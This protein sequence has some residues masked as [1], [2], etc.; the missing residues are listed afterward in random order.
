VRKCDRAL[1]WVPMRS[2]P[3]KVTG[4]V[5]SAHPK[6]PL[7]PLRS[8]RAFLPAALPAAPPA[9]P[10]LQHSL[11]YFVRL[12]RLMRPYWGEMGASLALGLVVGLLG[13]IGPYFTKSYFDRVYPARDFTLLHALVLGA[14]TL[15]LTTSVVGSLR[16][17]HADAIASKVSAAVGLMYFNHL[18]HLPV[19]FYE[20]RHV[21]E[22]VSRLSDVNAS[23]ATIARTLQTVLMSG[24]YFLIVPPFLISLSWKLSLVA[25][26]TTP[27]TIAVATFTGRTSRRL[28]QRSA[29]ASA[30]LVAAQVE[31]LSHIRLCKS[32]AA[33]H[34][35]YSDVRAHAHGVLTTHLRASG[36]SMVIA[37][38]NS[39]VAALGA[40]VFAWYAWTLV[41]RGEM[42]IGGYLAFA[43]YLGLLTGPA[44]QIASLVA[45]F[46]QSAVSL[47]RTF[48][49]LDH[50]PEQA[51]E[52][53]YERPAAIARPIR[54]ELTLAHV[55]FGYTDNS[56]I[57]R[58]VSLCFRPGT[59][60]ALVGGSGA[61]KSSLIKLLSRSVAA[62]RGALHVD[63]RPFSE[64]PLSEFRRQVSVVW[65]D[66]ALF[67]GTVLDNLVTRGEEIAASCLED[68]VRACRLDDYIA[69]LR[70]GYATPV[71]EWGANMSGGQRQR[72]AL[73]RA[74][75][76]KTPILLLDEATSQLDMETEDLVLR[77]IIARAREQTLVFATHRVATASLAHQ[78][79][80]LEEGRVVEFGTHE[81]LSRSNGI[82][83]RMLRVAPTGDAR[84]VQARGNA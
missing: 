2:A 69:C 81:H 55:S 3:L 62:N 72:F 21:G 64:V 75:L 26:M 37:L 4:P 42:T 10:S 1:Y 73:A 50:E 74:L 34:A 28:Y 31:I 12:L 82:Y 8:M 47:G 70:D 60:T 9:A 43:A 11:G 17:Y 29:E 38:I 45:D 14:L 78:V 40:A 54:G 7:S 52:S 6:L 68:A 44:G 36:G 46:Q 51:A 33:E 13:L 77:A 84:S 27:L 48:E 53:A 63:G 32:L 80:V 22:V 24:L 57:L 41:L 58:D 30:A 5:Q 71:A 59:V 61:G 23:L 16:G 66:Q 76:R 19:S 49:Y 18:Q 83:E 67:R 79:C 39:C 15:T 35:V 20:R 56:Q 25:L 65:Q